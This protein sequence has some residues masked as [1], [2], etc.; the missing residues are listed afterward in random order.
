MERLQKV[1][2]A[3]GVG[4]RRHCEGLI[5]AG[6]VRVNGEVAEVGLSVEPGLDQIELDGKKLE[7]PRQL[8]YLA[9]NKPVGYITTASDPQGRPTVMDLLPK[10]LPRVFPVGRLDRDTEGL[11]VLTNNGPL[12]HGLLHP[13]RGVRKLYHAT[14]RGR[15]SPALLKK[16]A[17]GVELE[18]G[19]TAPCRARLL[20]PHLVEIELKEGRKRQVRRML[21]LIGHPVESLRRVRF[22]PLE[23][24][25]IPLGKCRPIQGQALSELLAAAG[26]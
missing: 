24:G 23:L 26:L 5:R 12:A 13:T 22:G 9:L 7:G 15:P 8:V 6:R 21:G 20:G 17:A 14:V 2:A 25:E 11:L 3:A 4:S 18:D 16:L 1:M 10:N 19:P